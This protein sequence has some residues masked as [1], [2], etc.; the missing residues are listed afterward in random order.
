M[1]FREIFRFE[2]FYQFGRPSTWIFALAVLGLSFM[3]S[4]GF[5]DNAMSE[6]T[7]LN[8]PINIAG[9]TAFSNMFGLLMIAAL[10]GDA[11]MRDIQERM[12]PLVYTTP[13]SKFTLLAGRFL[14]AISVSA[15]LMML[16]VPLGMVMTRFMPEVDPI[17][18]G[19]FRLFAHLSAYMLFTLPNV[20]VATML[21]YSMAVLSRHAMA[22]YIGA[23]I[24]FLSSAFSMDIV[25]SLW[26]QWELAKLLDP[27]GVTIL[28]QLKIPLTTEE[29]NTQ[30]I[31][32]DGSLLSNR[33]LWMSISLLLFALA[34][35][36]F[37]FA[38]HGKGKRN[39]KTV[40]AAFTVGGSALKNPILLL[41]HPRNFD[42]K[43]RVQQLWTLSWH[44]FKEIV[45]NPACLVAPGI[46]IVLLLIGPE[47]LEGSLGVPA[48]PTTSRVVDLFN[49]TAI[50]FT[51]AVLI[52]LLAGQ[53]VWSERDARLSDIADVVPIPDKLI[54]ISRYGSLTLA[55]VSFQLL[56][57]VTGVIIQLMLGYHQLEV[58]LYF[59]VLLGIQLVDYL[60]F[61]AIAVAF[62]V[63][64]NQKY[65]AYMLLLLFYLYTTYPEKLGIEHK[66]L[67]FG[68]D[69]GLAYS[70]FGG[71][72]PS[73]EPWIWFKLYWGGW[74][75]LV[76]IVAKHFWIRGR[77][78][79]FQFRV[80][81]AW[82][83]AKKS[84]AILAAAAF[85]FALGI[86]IFYNTNFINPFYTEAERT[87]HRVD[88]EKKYGHFEDVAQPHLASTRL[89]IEIYPNEQEVVIKGRYHLT[90]KGER[91]IDSIHLATASEVETRSIRFDRQSKAV[92]QDQELGHQ[93]YL[94]EQPLQPGDS[95]QL[96]FDIYF[97]PKGFS[98]WGIN[99]TASQS[100]TYFESK[101][102]LPAI[103]YQP[104][105]ELND[106][107]KRSAYGLPS[108]PA[109][110]SL[111]NEKARKDLAGRET[112]PLEVIVGTDGDQL[113]IAPGRLR[114][115]WT[116]KGRR[117]FHY[118]T[119]QPIRNHYAI[120]SADYAV[121]EAQWEGVK[122]QVFHHPHDTLNLDRM[123]KSLQASLNY[124]TR[125]FGPYPYRELK[126]VQ[127][128]GSGGLTSFPTLITYSDDFA[129]LNPEKDPRQFDLPFA[130][131]AHEVAHQWWGNQLVPAYIEGAPLLTESLAWYSAM[132]VVKE[133]YGLDQLQRLLQVMRGAYLTPRSKADVPLLKATNKFLAYRKGPFAM[134]ALREY[135]GEE[136]VNI[137][138][139]HLLKNYRAGESPLPTS[140]DLYKELQRV[141]ADSLK[142]LLSDLFETNTYWELETKKAE[143]EQIDNE[144]W[145]VSLDVVARKVQ[146][147]TAGA[148]KEI[149]MDD[150]IEVGVF[151]ASG[152]EGELGKPLYLRQHRIHSGRQQISVMVSKEPECAGID[153]RNLLIDTEMYDNLKEVVDS[154]GA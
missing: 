107:R 59:K 135:V 79:S 83:G 144:N 85:T 77:E 50:T 69:T 97:Q 75:L 90:N 111:Y 42:F 102:W 28:K 36:R 115:T 39:R 55:L 138:L 37:Q 62:H 67:V 134:N 145:L 43:A 47:L 44:S 121:Q 30:M 133:A 54:L 114:Q 130:V 108:R 5:A 101:E 86:F 129:L 98:N 53:L 84:P 57:M 19:P 122:L 142:P 14:G 66:L 13:L 78:L 9:I 8:A 139:H 51:V 21:L 3:W 94:L 61:A 143:V 27:S 38:H 117:Y 109:I 48:V 105:R 113:V 131:I 152:E 4:M 89:H 150:L 68:S 25:G 153:P 87:E 104:I 136:K 81:Q 65:V 149:P 11:A 110:R 41:L 16:V 125:H 96:N 103:G 151:D 128:P 99:T 70:K 72:G 88:Y 35:F 15:L 60:L 118:V 18:F 20:F 56:M 45:T 74:A 52:I 58:N 154:T 34:Y 6:G 17:I 46:S 140:L 40:Q 1:K 2:V 26:N 137:A 127:Y 95:L 24:L 49:Q 73:V 10:A 106:L 116:E 80:R 141:S 132:A 23:I 7:F 123:V 146:V 32:L 76:M 119:D 124:Y 71:F 33:L 92:L 148:E 63:L 93:I 126:L 22:A 31:I 29:V 82:E 12:D 112:L 91:S 147:D 120:L 100:S 64:V